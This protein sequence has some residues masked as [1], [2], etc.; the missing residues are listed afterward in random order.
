MIDRATLLGRRRGLTELRFERGD[1]SDL[2]A[3]DDGAFD[4]ATVAM[5]LHEMPAAARDGALPEL[6]RVAGRVVVADFAAPMPRNRAGVRNRIIERLAGRAH[7]AGF[8]AY[9]EL[10]GLPALIEAA[11]AEVVRERTLDQ[12]TLVI[13]ELTR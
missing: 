2:R 9:Q 7:F 1:V 10:G 13:V 4:V 5:G 3:F 6:L 11:G 12:G 8:R